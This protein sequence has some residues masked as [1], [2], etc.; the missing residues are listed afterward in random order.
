M[1]AVSV[2]AIAGAA[3]FTCLGDS[4][5]AAEVHVYSHSFGEGELALTPQSGIAVNE[6]TGEVYVSD[7]DHS[8]IAQ[9]TAAGTAGSA[10]TGI[11]SPTFIAIDNSTGPS[12]GDIYVVEGESTVTKL[13]PAGAPVTSWGTGGHLG[14]AE[15]VIGVA[16]DPDGNLWAATRVLGHEVPGFGFEGA[17]VSGKE[18]D[19]AGTS[20]RS[21]TKALPV[22]FVRAARAGI[23]VDSADNLYAFFGQQSS[24]AGGTSIGEVDQISPAGESLGSLA[25]TSAAG[26]ANDPANGDLYLGSRNFGSPP[27]FRYG[28]ELLTGDALGS[29]LEVFG[30]EFE[31]PPTPV[32][33][34]AVIKDGLE[35]IASI[36][37]PKE[38]KV[39][40][41]DPGA[42]KPGKVALFDLEEVEPPSATIEPPDSVTQTS[43]HVVGH[44]D[45]N[46][47]TG[48]WPSHDVAWEFKCTPACP[49]NNGYIEVEVNGTEQ[50]VE[51]T[52]GKLEP[53]TKYFVLL[54]AKNR[55]GESEAPPNPHPGEP[56]LG[57]E[58]TTAPA[59]PSVTDKA[60]NEVFRGEAT[61]NAS[62]N[63]NGAETTYHFEY[64]TKAAYESEGFGGAQ[65]SRTPESEP[66][67]SPAMPRPVSSRVAG[68]EPA[69]E[70]IYR[71]VAHNFLGR[72]TAP[73]WD[74]APR[75]PPV[76]S[77]RDARMS[78]C[79]PMRALGCPTVVPT[80]WSRRWRR[81]AVLLK[82][83]ERGSRRR[84]TV[85]A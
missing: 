2:L 42:K 14:F 34:E 6:E 48:S 51:A 23:A 67:P 27:L 40:V 47:P 73:R 64:M 55:G 65:T 85:P 46:A 69:T 82:A 29:A 1:L 45:P 75:P 57:E 13:D 81:T 5:S 31:G 9:F 24:E 22:S 56:N 36:A 63:S 25:A 58:F 77:K 3:A 37:A 79:E 10:L 68:L 53:G 78:F 18:F 83:M 59:A 8:R 17:K 74:S 44:I 7:T 70:Y 66:L 33:R 50:T 52:I 71:A 41:L 49:G 26:I 28:P 60:V 61:L 4:A 72:S 20:I 54:V 30:G 21:W 38:G 11:S 12:K 43:A 39:Y 62:V 32:T 80:K 15:E 76:R 84:P 35:A 19:Q 16:V